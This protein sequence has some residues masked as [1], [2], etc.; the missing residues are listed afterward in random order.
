MRDNE[1]TSP[2]HCFVMEGWVG[3]R[4]INS[5]HLLA[6]EVKSR[7]SIELELEMPS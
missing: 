6:C 4:Y 1:L 7:Q 2:Q 3:V 5:K